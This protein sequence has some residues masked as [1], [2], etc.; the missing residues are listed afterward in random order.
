[1]SLLVVDEKDVAREAI[2][3]QHYFA[4]RG[5]MD[6]LMIKGM[7]DS[8]GKL[9][10]SLLKQAAKG[11]DC[12]DTVVDILARLGVTGMEWYA[13]Y[14]DSNAGKIRPLNVFDHGGFRHDVEEILQKKDLD[15]DAFS[16]EIR[17][18]MMYYFWS[19]CEYEVIIKE[20]VGVPAQ[21]HVDI[22]Q[23]VDMNWNHFIDYLWSLRK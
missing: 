4:I 14:H 22:F 19:K 16:K 10:A 20:W 11:R 15:R 12:Y 21:L 8:N 1:M 13:Y 23:Q 6:G 7:V 18:S 9:Y 3:T 17:S 5:L 2:R